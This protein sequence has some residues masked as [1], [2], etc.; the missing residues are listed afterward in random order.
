L[1]AALF[2]AQAKGTTGKMGGLVA[3]TDSG[4]IAKLQNQMS[5]SAPLSSYL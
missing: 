5:L 3:F 2:A 4:G 1:D